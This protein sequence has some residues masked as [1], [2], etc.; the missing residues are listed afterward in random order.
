M[1]TEKFIPEKKDSTRFSVSIHEFERK[2]KMKEN[3]RKER[4]KENERNEKKA[5]KKGTNLDVAMS[6][7]NPF[8]IV[9][10]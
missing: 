9:K 3:E 4:V 1:N 7:I 2:E 8:L 10:N 5:D 6:E